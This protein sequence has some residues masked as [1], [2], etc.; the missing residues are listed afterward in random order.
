MNFTGII[1]GAAVFLSIGICHPITIKLEYYFGR[2]GWWGFFI[3]GVICTAIS[4]IVDNYIA[5]TIIAAFAFSCFW[6]IHEVMQQERRVLRGWFPENPKRH[7]YYERRRK[8]LGDILKEGLG[9]NHLKEKMG[10]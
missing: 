5:S 7:A 8:E 3:P 10:K 6:G 1:I 4:L 9:H 2:K